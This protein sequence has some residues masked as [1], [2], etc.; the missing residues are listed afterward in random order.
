M[1]RMSPLSP[2]DAD[3][4]LGSDLLDRRDDDA[5]GG[6]AALDDDELAG[7]VLRP[8]AQ[9]LPAQD[10]VVLAAGRLQLPGD[11]EVLLLRRAEGADELRLPGLD[12]SEGDRP[13]LEPPGDGH[14][15]ALERLGE[16]GQGAAGDAQLVRL[17]R[18]L[19]LPD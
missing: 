6:Q 17:L 15:A 13:A 14:V 3:E 19:Q 10:E 16:P 1:N 7:Q 11:W 9:S 2:E 18:R 4:L 5:F 12:A 8:A